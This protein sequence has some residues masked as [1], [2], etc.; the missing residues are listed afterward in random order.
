MSQD[1][2][3]GKLALVGAVSGVIAGFVMIVLMMIVTAIAGQEFWATPKWIADAIYGSD[4]LGFNVQDVVTGLVIH[5]LL[6]IILG[7]VFGMIAVPLTSQPRQVLIFGLV[8]GI[9]AWILLTLLAMRAVDETMAQQVPVVPWFVV[10]LIFGLI[11]GYL[12][13]SLR[14]VAA[15]NA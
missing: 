10:H 11:L 9:L 14:Q 6:S 2:N 8:W 12:V 15:A 13:S 4:W 1:W 3:V 7:A 5:F